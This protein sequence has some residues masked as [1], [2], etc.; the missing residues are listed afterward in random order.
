M[1]HRPAPARSVTV[2]ELDEELCL[3][4]PD[5]DEVLVLNGPAGDVWR[6]ADGATSV[7]DIVSLLAT[8][9]GVPLERLAADVEAVVADLTNR[10]YLVEAA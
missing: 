10:G 8:A 4:R 5:I 3:F 6:L 2:E 7:A 1:L 9:Y